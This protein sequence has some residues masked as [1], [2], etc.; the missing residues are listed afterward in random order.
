MKRRHEKN[1]SPDQ[2]HYIRTCGKH[3]NVMAAELDVHE[4]TI[5]KVRSG[6]TYADH[7]TP[8]P[9]L[10]KRGG[11]KKAQRPALFAPEE[12]SQPGEDWR[13]VVGWERYYRVS[14]LGRVYSLHQTGRLCIGMPMEGGYRCVKV[15]D[16]ARRG[17]V[18]VHVM[19]LEA[20]VGPR[21]TPEHEG[22]HNDGE[23]RNCRLSN[24][25][26]DT[27]KGNQAD[28]VAHGTS[29]RGVSSP[30]KLTPELVHEIRTAGEKDA[31]WVE[32]LGAHRLTIQGARTGKTWQDVPTPPD[33][34]AQTN[35]R[36]A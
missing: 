28:K 4:A 35:R 32:R 1:L 26:W 5:R 13:P 3:Y 2:V 18:L 15:R 33:V 31:Y 12:F 16:K 19:V 7:P 30:R 24:L 29:L 14:T 25:R 17:H 27:A 10:P 36:P 22:C 34:R 23:P 6:R 21:P 11:W 9:V 8:P 20:F